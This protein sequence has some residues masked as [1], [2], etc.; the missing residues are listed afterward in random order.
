MLFRSLGT[1]GITGPDGKVTIGWID[2][3]GNRY[4]ITLKVVDY[5][6]GRPIEGAVVTI[7]K[8][9]NISVVLPDGIDIDAANRIL[10][11]SPPGNA[12]RD[13]L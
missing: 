9:R 6:N 12:I 5:E 1:S 10:E 13:L 11:D 2:A 7:G 4:T 3:D 8:T